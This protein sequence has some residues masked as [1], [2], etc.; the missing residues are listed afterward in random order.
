MT[1]SPESSPLVR[2]QSENVA[3]WLSL[4]GLLLIAIGN[5]IEFA[6][7][8]IDVGAMLANVGALLLIIGVLQWFFD[9]KIR[10][11]FF[12]AIRQEIVGSSRIAESGMSDF[13]PDS[14]SVDFTEHFL[15]SREVTVGVNYSAKLIDNSIS[16]LQGRT[17]RGFPTT[18]VAI[19]PESEAARFLAIDYEGSDV[20]H[21]I[22]KIQD[23]VRNVDPGGR[24]IKVLLVKTVLRYS[25]VQFDSRIWI[26]MSTN[27]PGRRAVPGFYVSRGKVWFSHFEDDIDLLKRRI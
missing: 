3:L 21:G 8:K 6:A 17:E 1:E 19:D 12:L 5:A 22:R 25:F 27:G 26:V 11:S 15:S 13:F 4:G 14:K 7:W 20:S 18:I 24:L 10:H 2:A 16:L 9:R 23:I